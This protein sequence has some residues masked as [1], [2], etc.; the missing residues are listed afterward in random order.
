M[1]RMLQSLM[2]LISKPLHRARL[3]ADLPHVS[4]IIF[5]TLTLEVR[6]VDLVAAVESN[7]EAVHPYAERL[8]L[9]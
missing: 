1:T 6:T 3:I 9:E 8:L 5:D 4:R 7:G 2:E